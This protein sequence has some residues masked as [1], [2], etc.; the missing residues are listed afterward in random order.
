M[1]NR[2]I[3]W[4]PTYLLKK[5]KLN[6]RGYS[7]ETEMLLKAARFVHRFTHVSVRAIYG[8]APHYRPFRDTWVISWGAVY[9]KV[10][11]PD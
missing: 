2:A 6:A 3:A 7:I 11:E 5:L 10:F 8:G 9:Y 1:R 4:S